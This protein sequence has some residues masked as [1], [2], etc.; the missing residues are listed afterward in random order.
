MALAAFIFDDSVLMIRL[1]LLF[2]LTV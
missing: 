1:L 2:I